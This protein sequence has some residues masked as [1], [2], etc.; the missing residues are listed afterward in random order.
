MFAASPCNSSDR[1]REGDCKRSRGRLS[2]ARD[3][4]AVGTNLRLGLLSTEAG[5][6]T[7]VVRSAILRWGTPEGKD[8]DYE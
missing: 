7:A 5:E 8:G 4:D 2:V 3:G 1:G 6:N